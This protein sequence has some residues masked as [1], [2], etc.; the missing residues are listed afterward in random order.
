MASTIP[1][2]YYRGGSSKAVFL[3]EKDIPPAGPSRDSLLKR[4]MGTPDPIQV[5]GMGGSRVI[6][7]KMAIISKSER[8]DADVNYTFAQVGISDDYIGYSGNCGNISAAVGPFAISEGLVRAERDG[9]S[10]VKG[11]KTR[12]VRIYNTG[13]DKVLTAHVPVTEEGRVVESGD[14]E[15]AAV[16]GTGAPILM[17]YSKVPIRT[18]SVQHFAENIRRNH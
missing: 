7:S 5:D 15:V 2:V 18:L 8:K 17:D 14:Y 3:H 12:E 9:V 1:A 10:L 11:L 6:T 13:T 4:L 16:P